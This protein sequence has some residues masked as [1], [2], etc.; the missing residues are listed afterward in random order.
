MI[1]STGSLS[2]EKFGC[3]LL[4]LHVHMDAITTEVERLYRKKVNGTVSTLLGSAFIVTDK[5]LT[6]RNS[7]LTD[8]V[9]QVSRRLRLCYHLLAVSLQGQRSVQCVLMLCGIT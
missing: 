3:V 8:N 7:N 5:L 6:C 9:R 4:H 2:C 1:L